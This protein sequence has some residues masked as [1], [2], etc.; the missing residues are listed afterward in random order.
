MKDKKLKDETILSYDNYKD[1]HGAVVPPLYQNS[2]FTFE[3]WDHIDKAFDGKYENFIYSRLLNPTVK[4]AE[5][6][7]AAICGGE[8]AKLC[9]SGIAAITSAILHCVNA[10]D[11]IITIQNIY[12]PTNNFISKYLKE[13]FNIT[14]TFIDGKDV[15]NFENAIQENTKLIYLESPASLT[16][17]LQDLKAI[18]ALAKSRSI[19]TV[20]DNT[21]ASPVFQ[22]PLKL[23]IDIEVH[24]VSKYLGGHSDVVAGVIVSKA[25]I[26]DSI[27]GNEHELLGAKMA[28]FEGWLIL[29]SLRTLMIRMKAHQENAMHVSQYLENH[30]K[31]KQVFYPGLESFPQ[32][33][34]AQKQMTGSSGLLSFELQTKDI[35]KIKTFVDSLTFFKLGVSW[36]GHD[37]LVYAPVISYLKE[38]SPEKFEAMGINASIIRISVGLENYQDLI[39]D[40]SDSLDLI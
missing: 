7:I 21:W 26:L 3:S 33:D 23:G 36:G 18:S 4:V 13:K 34:L 12:G 19:K 17:E 35:Q 2:L 15:K 38:L 9:A 29:R 30:D 22:K 6:K 14:S 10:N 11:H 28:P 20:I 31:V 5:D 27:L 37:S 40:L 24:S 39:G 25:T 32:Y 1:Q 8:K 16:Y